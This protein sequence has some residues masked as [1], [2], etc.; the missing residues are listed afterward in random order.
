MPVGYKPFGAR[1][2]MGNALRGTRSNRRFLSEYSRR[3]NDPYFSSRNFMFTI[4]ND[5][6]II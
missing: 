6:L 2:F 1:H 5:H 4:L 3:K